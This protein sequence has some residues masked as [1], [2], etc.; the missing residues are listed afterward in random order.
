M[1]PRYV[2][3]HLPC[4]FQPHPRSANI[5]ASKH[6]KTHRCSP[7]GVYTSFSI[8]TVFLESRL[9]FDIETQDRL[10]SNPIG[11]WRSYITSHLVSCSG[12]VVLHTCLETLASCPS[13]YPFLSF[14]NPG[15]V[16]AVFIYSSCPP[17]LSVGYI[18]TS[19][20]YTC[21]LFSLT[22][23]PSLSMMIW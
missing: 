19:I 16:L 14:S 4:L 7:V 21:Y 8:Q 12:L 23:K 20:S 13:W 15:T 11:M 18:Y 22:C 2:N 1:D 10:P 5:A 9:C 3:A 6:V 17:I